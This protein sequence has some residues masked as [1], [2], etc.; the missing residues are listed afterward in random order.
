L[1]NRGEKG[2]DSWRSRG[3]RAERG[4]DRKTEGMIEKGREGKREIRVGLEGDRVKHRVRDRGR[5]RGR[6]RGVRGLDR[7]RAQEGDRGRNRERGVDEG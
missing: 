3:D 4:T 2:K 6:D 1:R 5:N 7:G